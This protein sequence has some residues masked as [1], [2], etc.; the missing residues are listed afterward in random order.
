MTAAMVA[1]L[2]A[3]GCSANVL[4]AV[5]PCDG[6]VPT[7]SGCTSLLEELVGWWR[8][9][10]RS[11]STVAQDYS[12][13]LNNG[14]LMDLDAAT[15]WGPGRSAGGLGVESAGYI[16]VMPS[17]SIDSITDQMTISGWGYLDAT[18]AIDDYATIASREDAATIDQHYHISVNSRGEFP[19]LFLKTATTGVML[20]GPTAVKR[21]TWVHIAGTYDG[22]T[23]RLYVDGQQVASQA[24]TGA[25][26]P[27]NTPFILGANGNGPDIG[28]SERFPGRIDEIMLYR[29]ALAA[30]DIAQLHDGVLF[31]SAPVPD[32]DA[33]ARD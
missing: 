24:L 7:A 30:A 31:G 19:A 23:G 32:R 27:D 16:N 26:A 17:P 25:F 9:D 12:G 11:G 6:G 10:E 33:G 1:A 3:G 13:N 14:T 8:L 2:A 20:Q 18:M 28:V 22:M 15:A 21:Q 29:R 5:H 4:V